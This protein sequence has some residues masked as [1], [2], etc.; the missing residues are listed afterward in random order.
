MTDVD[1]VVQ[2]MV[3]NEADVIAECL[4][5]IACWGDRISKIVVVDGE[6]DDGTVEIVQ[7][8]AERTQGDFIDLHVIPDPPGDSHDQVR[9]TM[10]EITRGHNPDWIISLDADEIYYTDPVQAIDQA[11]AAGANVVVCDVPQFWLTYSDLRAG[12]L[13]EDERIPVVDRRRWYSWGHMGRFIWKDMPELFYR[14][15]P[16]G[17]S[18]RTPDF[19]GKPDF[20]EWQKVGP[21]RPVCRHYCF[22]SI[23]Q[24]AKRAHERLSR[25]WGRK[26]FGKYAHDWI[27]DEKR[28]GLYYFYGLPRGGDEWERRDNHGAVKDWMGR[29]QL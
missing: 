24:A 22:R 28:A 10:L 20:R 17:R 19:V 6:S 4:A 8:F 9:Q 25:D 14:V 29:W 3:R 27:I 5:E 12:L 15:D 23:F 1:I 2:M 26:H 16:P 13:I 7:H 18:Q 21:E 11:E